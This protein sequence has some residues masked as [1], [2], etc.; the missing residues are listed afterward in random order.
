MYDTSL[1]VDPHRV[2]DEGHRLAAAMETLTRLTPSY[3]GPQQP[4][5][6]G[7]PGCTAA[8]ATAHQQLAGLVTTA[9]DQG[10]LLAAQVGRAARQYATLDAGD[11]ERQ[12]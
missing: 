10:R 4:P 6:L 2:V 11:P 12:P 3:R 1:S 9:V 8:Y 7:D 5:P